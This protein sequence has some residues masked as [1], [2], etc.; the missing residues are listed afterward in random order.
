VEQERP[1]GL[2]PKVQAAFEDHVHAEGR[3][4]A[5]H[6]MVGAC[7]DAGMT[8]QEALAVLMRYGPSVDKYGSGKLLKLQFERS[9]TKIVDE[10]QA[11]KALV[12]QARQAEVEQRSKAAAADPDRRMVWK[13]DD[14]LN[15]EFK[16]TPWVIRGL[17]PQG[18]TVLAG[19]P[20]AKK[21][22][23]CL[24]LVM[25][26]GAGQKALGQI[27]TK[28]Q[29][30][31]YFA[32]EDTPARLKERVEQMVDGVD[33][34]AKVT[35]IFDWSTVDEQGNITEGIDRLRQAIEKNKPAL[36]IIDTLA[37]VRTLRN[38]NEN[39]YNGDYRALGPFKKLADE[40]NVAIILVH[41]T[42]KDEQNS[43]PYQSISGTYG[44]SGSA[45]TLM[46]LMPERDAK[47]RLTK[48]AGLN[49][50]GRQVTTAEER[51]YPLVFDANTGHWRM[52]ATSFAMQFAVGSVKYR[53]AVYLFEHPG[54]TV[55]D[56]CTATDMK[57]ESIRTAL[58]RMMLDNQVEQVSKIQNF[59]YKL[60]RDFL[61]E[62]R[63]ERAEVEEL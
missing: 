10:R 6:R 51:P 15:H 16:P 41:H 25:A 54:S 52:D 53:V 42:R 58:K 7:V 1:E 18:L 27:P 56:V 48:N 4:G 46:V 45:D 35:F 14:L 13:F 39:E 43:D 60:T 57:R 49:V 55:K 31:I 12:I 9:W 47:G 21:S 33:T 11:D 37:M 20:K 5:H 30:C 61:D 34:H 50:R 24:A 22:W 23:L 29:R 28:K 17:L 40:F 19:P 36:V 2:P 32:L 26:V 62:V 8:S 3:S 38:K 59:A 44:I 63:H